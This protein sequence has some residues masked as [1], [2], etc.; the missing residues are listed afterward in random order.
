MPVDLQGRGQYLELALF[1]QNVVSALLE[2]VDKDREDR[3]ESSLKEALASLNAV[4]SGDLNHLVG[5]RVAAFASYAQ[6]KTLN[7][8]WSQADKDEAA[9]MIRSL[10]QSSKPVAKKKAQAE[11]LVGLFSKLQNQALRDFEQPLNA[12]VAR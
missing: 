7:E 9:S 8:V 10:L 3:L 2:F 12:A 4:A 1:S 5:E 11:R 6:L